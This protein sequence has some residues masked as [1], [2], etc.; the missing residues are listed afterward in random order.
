[1]LIGCSGNIGTVK[2]KETIANTTEKYISI[3][4]PGQVDFLSAYPDSLSFNNQVSMGEEYLDY[5]ITD[6]CVDANNFVMKGDPATCTKHRNI[7]IGERLPFIVTD[8]DKAAQNRK[9]QSVSSIPMVGTDGTLKIMVSKHFQGMKS[10]YSE[11]FKFD[12]NYDNTITGYDLLDANGTY[13]SGIRTSDGGCFDQVFYSNY[14]IRQNGWIFFSKNLKEGS[15]NHNIR[16]D[17]LEQNLPAGCDKSS[18]NQSATTR[19]VWNAPTSFTFESAKI[20]KTIITYHYAHKDLTRKNN[21]LER[22][23]FTKEYGFTRWE[24]WQPESRC[25]EEQTDKTICDPMNANHFLRG[26]CSP[27]DGKTSWGNQTW[28]RLDCRDTTFYQDLKISH[29]PIDPL[30]ANT[31]GLNDVY[32]EYNYILGPEIFNVHYYLAQNPD[33]AKSVG[34][35][36]YSAATMHWIQ[37]G[38]SEGRQGSEKFHVKKYVEKYSDVKNAYGLNYKKAVIHYSL[39]GIPEG[40]S[41]L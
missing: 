39:Y 1:M 19:D 34:A 31:N 36:N 24:S 18:T 33:V 22:F 28:V 32:S 25:L 16:L 13:V 4:M 3:T 26:R 41:G 21:A 20:L 40:R 2:T 12:Y 30:M 6:V 29:I 5:L 10:T 8:M 9:Y 11:N 38:I 17:R 35:T 15:V 27:T 7:R 14:P 23:F 37:T